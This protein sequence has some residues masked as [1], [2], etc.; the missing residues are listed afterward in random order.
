MNCVVARRARASHFAL[1]G[2][3][4]AGHGRRSS[5]EGCDVNGAWVPIDGDDTESVLPFVNRSGYSWHAVAMPQRPPSGPCAPMPAATASAS[6]RPPGAPSRRRG[7]RPRWRT[8]PA[9]RGL[10]VGTLYRHFPTKEAL[11]G[12]LLAEKFR[13]LREAPGDALEIER[14]VGGVRRDA[15]AKR[16]AD[17]R[18]TPRCRTCSRRSEAEWPHAEGPRASSWRP[19]RR[20][21]TAGKRPASCATTSRST[22]SRC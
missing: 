11:I 20:P 3:R 14:S 13:L 6:S 12:E 9:G 22:T 19:S 18:A 7:W 5:W 4:S 1:S 10:G 16:R 21:S 15:A 17:G 2:V 8:W